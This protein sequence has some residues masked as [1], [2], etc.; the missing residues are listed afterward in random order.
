M[1]YQIIHTTTDAEGDRLDVLDLDTTS[2][3]LIFRFNE[4]DGITVELSHDE[5]TDLR[6]SLT[7][8]L[9]SRE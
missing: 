3:S 4:E 8:W 9:D 7:A 5:V 6:D 1:S 2:E